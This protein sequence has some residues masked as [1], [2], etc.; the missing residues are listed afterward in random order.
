[1]AEQLPVR[2]NSRPFG[3]C[4]P[5]VVAARMDCHHG[6]QATYAMLLFLRPDKRVLHPDALAKYAA[7]FFRMSRSSVTRFCS[8]FRRRISAPYSS[9]LA[10]RCAG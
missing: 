3:A 7:A 1:M 10:R 6:T 9:A 2:A 5:R 4:P 8:A